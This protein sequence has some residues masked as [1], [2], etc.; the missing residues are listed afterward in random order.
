[1]N[2]PNAMQT[3]ERIH[4]EGKRFDEPFRSVYIAASEFHA[5]LAVERQ[6]PFCHSVIR[7]W[8][9]NETVW[10]IECDCGRCNDTHKGL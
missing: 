2:A 8:A 9:L 4:T 6:C 3:R 1:M 5:G 7:V 10:R